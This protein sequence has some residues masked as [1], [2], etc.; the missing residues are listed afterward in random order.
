M[1]RETEAYTWICKLVATTSPEYLV[2]DKTE[3]GRKAQHQVEA[4]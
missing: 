1:Q 3:T 2:R 4:G